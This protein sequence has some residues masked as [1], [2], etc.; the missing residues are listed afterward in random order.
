MVPNRRPPHFPKFFQPG[1][2]YSNTPG[3]KFLENF[4]PTQGFKI[5]THF[6]STRNWLT[7]SNCFKGYLITK[8]LKRA[9][10]RGFLANFLISFHNLITFHMFQRFLHLFAEIKYVSRF[11][12]LGKGRKLSKKIKLNVKQFPCGLKYRIPW[13]KSSICKYLTS[14]RNINHR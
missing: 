7:W 1:H 2:F 10:S 5:Y 8:I 12:S 13:Q 4:L 9:Y 6:T 14:N 3:I 11:I